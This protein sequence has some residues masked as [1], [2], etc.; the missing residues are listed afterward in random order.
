MLGLGFGLNR[1]RRI[2]GFVGLLDLYPNAA[3]AYSLRKLRAAYSG[4]AVRVRESGGGTEADIGFTSAGDLDTTALLAH[5]GANDGFVVTWYDQSG[6]SNDATQATAA[7]QPKIV[8]AGSLVTENGKAAIDFDGVD[9]YLSFTATINQASEFSHF[10]T[11]KGT[12]FL[13]GTSSGGTDYLRYSGYIR[14]A[15]NSTLL[16]DNTN[17]D[18]LQSQTSFIRSNTDLTTI[19]YNSNTGVSSTL[20]GEFS[21]LSIGSYNNGAILY[22]GNIQEFIVFNSDQSA[23]R[24]GIETNINTF[25]SIYP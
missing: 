12:G 22:T 14:I 13:Y 7:N 23:N 24:T 16:T 6:N 9:D 11:L 25:Y 20:S 3:A 19:Y 1:L 2:G 17:V 15:I 18:N 5:C 4:S 10:I 8:S 21:S